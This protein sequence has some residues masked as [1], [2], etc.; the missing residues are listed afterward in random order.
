MVGP[1]AA[2]LVVSSAV[3]SAVPTA[4]VMAGTT[5]VPMDMQ[6]A[7]HLVDLLAVSLAAKKAANWADTTVVPKAAC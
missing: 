1:K 2:N 7:E 6:K 5:A 4:A 3:L